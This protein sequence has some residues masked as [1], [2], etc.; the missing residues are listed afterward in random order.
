MLG[1]GRIVVLRRPIGLKVLRANLEFLL[2]RTLLARCLCL[3]ELRGGGDVGHVFTLQIGI[4][5]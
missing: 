4:R 2:Q 3:L 1:Q 5:R